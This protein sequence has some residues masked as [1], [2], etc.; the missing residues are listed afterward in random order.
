MNADLMR[1]PGFGTI[2]QSVLP[3]GLFA[4]PVGFSFVV[5][6]VCMATSYALACAAIQARTSPTLQAVTRSE[7][8]TGFTNVPFF[9]L[10]Q[11][12]GAE[13]GKGAGLSG[14]LGLWTSCDSRMN[15]PSGSASNDGIVG[16]VVCS[17]MLDAIG[18]LGDKSLGVMSGFLLIEGPTVRGA[19]ALE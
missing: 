2:T 13:N 15:A 17:G 3:A 10:R 9:T 4:L 16:D 14:C 8:F 1:C 18:V 7:S 19:Y 11:R 6:S 12:V 5:V